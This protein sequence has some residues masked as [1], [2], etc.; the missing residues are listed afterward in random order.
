MGNNR[1][2]KKNSR[3]EKNVPLSSY[4]SNLEKS[5]QN[6]MLFRTHNS[7]FSEK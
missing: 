4:N 5:S 7:N 2:N 1:D 6:N 3:N